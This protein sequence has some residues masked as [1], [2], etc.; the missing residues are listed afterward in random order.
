M[1]H[2]DIE[3]AKAQAIGNNNGFVHDHYM[4]HQRGADD[5]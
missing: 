1:H 2:R 4:Q 3:E 5:G